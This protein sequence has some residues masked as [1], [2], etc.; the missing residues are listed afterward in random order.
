M[1][2]VELKL[3]VIFVLFFVAFG[4]RWIFGQKPERWRRHR[5]WPP[6]RPEAQVIPF[7]GHG[8]QD[9]QP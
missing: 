3:A 8:P 2:A 5:F 7:P 6:P 9:P 4:L 1:T